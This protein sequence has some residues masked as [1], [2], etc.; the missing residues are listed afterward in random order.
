MLFDFNHFG[1]LLEDLIKLKMH[2]PYDPITLF[3]SIY[4]EK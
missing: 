3:L 1:E 4:Q 2:P